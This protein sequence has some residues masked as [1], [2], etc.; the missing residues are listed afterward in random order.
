MKKTLT[1][2]CA[3]IITISC[4]AL[5]GCGKGGNGTDASDSPYLGT[6]KAVTAEAL[7]QEVPIAEVLD[8]DLT[9]TLNA[10]GSAQLEADGE[11]ANGKWSES[12]TEVKVSGSDMN[13]T[14]K[15]E[16]GKLSTSIV[17]VTIYFEKQ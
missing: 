13:M 17:G 12:G 14:L 2:L 4:I 6:W 5:A 15:D 1:I 3:L 16:G 10:D 8:Y 11:V 7:G 9:L